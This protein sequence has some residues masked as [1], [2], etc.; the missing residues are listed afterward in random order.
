M[1]G[2]RN[3]V[4]FVVGQALC[5]QRIKQGR[6]II[7]VVA[8]MLLQKILQQAFAYV[9]K[10]RIIK[11]TQVLFKMIAKHFFRLFSPALFGREPLKTIFLGLR[12]NP[13]GA[14]PLGPAGSFAPCT[15]NV[16]GFSRCPVIFCWLFFLRRKSEKVT[17]LGIVRKQHFTNFYKNNS[18][19]LGSQKF[20]QRFPASL[21]NHSYRIGTHIKRFGN[22]FGFHAEPIGHLDN[23]PITPG[24]FA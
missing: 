11:G 23:M 9:A 6:N 12:L 13:Q 2:C 3:T 22:I 16:F 19:S 10:D 17:F 20:F 5:S 4:Q 21:Q 1:A 18:T 15:P 24:K 14:L 7:G 8:A